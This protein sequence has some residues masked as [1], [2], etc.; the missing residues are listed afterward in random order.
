MNGLLM[1]VLALGAALV[2]APQA[3]SPAKAQAPQPT[4]GTEAPARRVT[5]CVDREDSEG[6]LTLA[7]IKNG[8][9]ELTGASVKPYVGKRVEL[10]GTSRPLTVTGGLYPSA[11][12]AAQAGAIDP[13]QT[14]FAAVSGGATHDALPRPTLEFRV[15]K[16]RTLKGTCPQGDTP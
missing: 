7:D 6:R 11:N 9:Y 3:S 1:A 14:T 2:G 8:T 15:E 5:G 12:I 4:A 16:V 10:K 13:L